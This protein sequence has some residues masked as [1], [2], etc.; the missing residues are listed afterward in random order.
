MQNK[1]IENREVGAVRDGNIFYKVKDRE[2][3]KELWKMIGCRRR[4]E[5]IGESNVD[6]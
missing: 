2:W 4:L 6:L 1:R 3:V 5:R